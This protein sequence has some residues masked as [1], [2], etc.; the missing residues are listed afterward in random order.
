MYAERKLNIKFNNILSFYNNLS[1]KDW[2]TILN[3]HNQLNWKNV[4]ELINL[5]LIKVWDALK[6]PFTY[7]V[8]NKK[9]IY[10]ENYITGQKKKSRLKTVQRF[11]DWKL[12]IHNIII[13][14]KIS[15]MLKTQ[16]YE[17]YDFGDIFF[18]Y[19]I[20]YFIFKV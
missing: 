18:I 3:I 10:I 15:N 11:R 6:L 4:K 1:I 14:A 9:R 17:S 2:I 16:F 5:I 8:Y 13:E 20:F 19:K 7:F 12:K